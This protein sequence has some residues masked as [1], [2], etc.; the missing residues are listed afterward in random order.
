[1]NRRDVMRLWLLLSASTALAPF[2]VLAETDYPQRPI[3]LIVPFAAGGVVDV[4]GR[5]WGET[6]QSVLGTI[7]IEN[8][9]GAGGTIGALEVAR[10]QPDGHTLLLGNTSTQV[11]NPAVMP[12]A[13]NNPATE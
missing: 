2:H 12:R 7:V 6:I 3:R 5:L 4:I 1:M 11:L 13:P 9:G 8:H 10:A